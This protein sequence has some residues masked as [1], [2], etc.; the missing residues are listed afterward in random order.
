ML[1]GIKYEKMKVMIIHTLKRCCMLLN[2]QEKRIKE[3]WETVVY[4]NIIAK[5]HCCSS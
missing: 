4:K 5:Q 3:A 1:E 2:D